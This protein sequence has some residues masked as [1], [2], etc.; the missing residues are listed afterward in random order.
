MDNRFGSTSKV[1]RKIVLS[2]RATTI[3]VM[4]SS[5]SRNVTT[6]PVMNSFESRNFW[7]NNKQGYDYNMAC[8]LYSEK[9]PQGCIIYNR[10]HRGK[11]RCRDFTGCVSN[12]GISSIKSQPI[13]HRDVKLPTN[14]NNTKAKS[15]KALDICQ[16][17]PSEDQ[18]LCIGRSQEDDMLDRFFSDFGT[19][20]NF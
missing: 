5:E 16:Y 11:K 4:N 7:N 8:N 9:N 17:F 3:P 10:R 20:L 6:C 12:E 1:F 2:P 13:G 15:N 18:A 19:S 14:I